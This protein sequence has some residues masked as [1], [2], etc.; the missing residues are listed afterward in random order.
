M[1]DPLTIVSMARESANLATLIFETK[2]AFK[3]AEARLKMA[4]LIN[5]LAAMRVEA[6]KLTG[7]IVDRDTEIA[8]LKRAL[9]LETE[10]TFEAPAYWQLV[11]EKRD[12]PFCQKC[13]DDQRKQSRLSLMKRARQDFYNCAVC[14]SNWD[15]GEA[16]NVSV[17]RTNNA[18]NS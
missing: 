18:W 2:D 7:E 5:A 10:M 16:K 15:H 9:A 8:D 3:D 17:R 1:F 11:G 13:W 12:G 4:D 6:A 14:N